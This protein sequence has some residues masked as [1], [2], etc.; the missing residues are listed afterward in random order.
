MQI[1]V[2]WNF[3]KILWKFWKFGKFW[4]FLKFSKIL[5][6]VHWPC[7]DPNFHPFRSISY[8]FRDQPILHKNRR[9]GS[10]FKIFEPMTLKY[11]TLTMKGHFYSAKAILLQ[12]LKIVHP[13]VTDMLWTKKWDAHPP[14]QAITITQKPAGCGLTKTNI[15][16]ITCDNLRSNIKM[17]ARFWIYWLNLFHFHFVCYHTYAIKTHIFMF[18][19]I[20]Y[21]HHHRW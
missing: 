1:Y 13:V 11:W 16:T 15:A 6:C 7:S 10:F 3:V 17:C 12:I 8:R 5:C 19:Q 14:P 18:P 9:I 2:F 21:G 20:Q 4:L